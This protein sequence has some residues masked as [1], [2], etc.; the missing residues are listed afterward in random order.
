MTTRPA[1]RAQKGQALM[2]V[3]WETVESG[4]PGAERTVLLLPGGLN[5]ARSYAEVMAQPT[6]AGVHLI[7]ATLPGHGGTPPPADFSIEN[8]AR[9]AA[10]LA[11]DLGCDVVAGFSIGAS[12]ALEMTASGAFKGPVVLLGPSLSLKDEPAFLRIMDRLGSVL[13]S[14]PSALMLKMIPLVAN[15]A[16]VTEDRRAELLADLRKND[17]AIMRQIFRGYLRYLGRH[18][19]P[20]T[21]LCGA[22]VPAWVVHAD[23]GD[24]GLTRTERR[25]L[26]E[27]P[28]TSVITIPGTSYLIPN[29]EPERIAEYLVEALGHAG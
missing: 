11:A 4:P 8:Y 14:L 28:H 12:V 23:K 13:G 15:H 21:R 10:E 24:G 20:A 25:T 29:E 5:T 17:P 6:L 3:E 1:S 7:A 22:G 19:A 26:E 2:K 18:D 9:M 27:C 16:R